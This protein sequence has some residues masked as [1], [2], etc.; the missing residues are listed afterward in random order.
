MAKYFIDTE[1][2]EHTIPSDHISGS[3][4]CVIPT[5]DLISIGIVDTTGREFYELHEFDVRAAWENKWLHENVLKS[6]FDDL[7]KGSDL[8]EFLIKDF[9]YIISKKA[10]TTN[11]LKNKIIEF[12]ADDPKPEFYGY[13]CDYDWVVFCWLFGRMIDLPTHFPKY[14]IDLKQMMDEAGLDKEW[15]RENCPGPENEHNALADARWNLQL[16]EAI[17]KTPILLK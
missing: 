8:F 3:F 13:Y 7:T 6:I 14:C 4:G 17:R 11:I 16:Y 10:L 1:F 12:I 2:H 15:K 9:I 5:I